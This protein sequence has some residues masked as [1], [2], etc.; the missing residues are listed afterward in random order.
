[1]LYNL[2]GTRILVKGNGEIEVEENIYIS[3]NITADYLIT[4]LI[5]RDVTSSQI[6]DL[7]T[8]IG[9]EKKNPMIWVKAKDDTM[10]IHRVNIVRN[11]NIQNFVD[12]FGDSVM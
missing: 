12:K 3:N 7:F 5:N 11:D 2:S 10:Y 4:L 9:R 8:Q 1:M 6:D